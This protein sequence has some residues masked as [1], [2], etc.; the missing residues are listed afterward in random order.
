[1][2]FLPFYALGDSR[3]L[4]LP[5]SHKVSRRSDL[6]EIRPGSLVENSKPKSLLNVFKT[7]CFS[8]TDMKIRSHCLIVISSCLITIATVSRFVGVNVA[9]W[10]FRESVFRDQQPLARGRWGHSTAYLEF[11]LPGRSRF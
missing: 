10:V 7:M 4:L 9:H 3:L 5:R 11:D 1:L 2:T 8:A 6:H